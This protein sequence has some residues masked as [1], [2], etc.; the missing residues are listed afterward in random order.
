MM[1]AMVSDDSVCGFSPA[2]E[3]IMEE[4][5]QEE[6]G[7]CQVT[8]RAIRGAASKEGSRDAIADVDR[9]TK[10]RPGARRCSQNKNKKRS[11]LVLK[12]CKLKLS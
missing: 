10:T 9:S 7:A 6:S 4:G 3:V 5:E 11:D 2:L 8:V 12:S 1:K